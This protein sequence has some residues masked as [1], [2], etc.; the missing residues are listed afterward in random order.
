[1]KQS[2]VFF[3]VLSV[4]LVLLGVWYIYP[5]DGITVADGVTLRFSSFRQTLADLN[6]SPAAD[7]DSVLLR[8]Q[9]R[10]ALLD[11]TGD[12]LSVFLE[13]L[14]EDPNRILLPEG[15]YRYF[16]SLFE[17]LDSA[18][19]KG[20]T[21]RIMHYGDSQ[22]EMDRISSVLRQKLQERFGGCGPGM[23]PLIQ[24]VASSSVM[25]SHSGSM[26]RYARVTDSLAHRDPRRRYGIMTS[27]V[28]V[29]NGG[30]FSFKESPSR[31]CQSLARKV[32]K[33]SILKADRGEKPFEISLQGYLGDSLVVRTEQRSGDLS[34]VSWAFPDTISS[35]SFNLTGQGDVYGIMLD[36]NG[37]VTVDN[38]ALRGSSGNIFTGID[39]LYMSRLFEMAG[40]EM[41]ILEFGGN[42]MPGISG[43]KS[44]SSY[45][46][47]LRRQF[48]YFREVAPEASLLFVGPADMSKRVNGQMVSWP[49][50]DELVDSLKVT[51]LDSGVA[52]WDTYAMM[53]GENSM[54][55]WVKHDPPL[56]GPDYIHFT[57]KGSQ[58][59]GSALS[60]S[61]L[62]LYDFYRFRK[63]HSEDLVNDCFRSIRDS[64][65]MT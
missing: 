53:G 61:F 39:S 52:F 33:V 18:S 43:R 31:F 32:C 17:T 3:F 6:G 44:I 19:A 24:R 45:M 49:M 23:V 63:T 11:S 48:G 64:L 1:M 28:S 41:I 36:G 15:D 40:H 10:R 14:T 7:I 27:Y 65:G 62:M 60:R 57:T 9:Q 51:C 8:E 58:E 16:D 46:K 21:V 12:S 47:D 34:L 25:L 38:V 30:K 59:V 35:A 37:G 2:G 42:A 29:S 13:Y 22:L 55:Q 54:V 4:L 5:A 20:R 26:S 50:L 56:A